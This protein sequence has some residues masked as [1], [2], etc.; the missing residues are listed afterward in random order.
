MKITK[1]VLSVLGILATGTAGIAL[2]VKP[3]AADMK[4][5]TGWA[6]TAV[7]L[8]LLGV[9]CLWLLRRKK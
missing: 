1:P 3:E 9:A 4:V 7:S 2:M 5:Q 8:W 6:L